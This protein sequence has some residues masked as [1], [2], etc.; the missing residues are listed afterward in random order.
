MMRHVAPL[1][2]EHLSLTGDYAW[3][4]TDAPAPDELRPL[5]AKPSLLAA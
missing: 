2:W 5:G 3:D 4:T 1:G